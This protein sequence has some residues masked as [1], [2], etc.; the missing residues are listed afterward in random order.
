MG[1]PA[2]ALAASSQKAETEDVPIL[3]NVWEMQSGWIGSEHPS[4]LAILN[5]SIAG[6]EPA[7]SIAYS[8]ILHADD[9]VSEKAQ[10]KITQ[11]LRRQPC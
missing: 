4:L 7:P 1:T 3:H 8:G 6:I 5:H 11:S 2:Q 9:M 10:A